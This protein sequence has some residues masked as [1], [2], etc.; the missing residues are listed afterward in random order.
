[1]EDG[2]DRQEQSGPEAGGDD[3]DAEPQGLVHGSVLSVCGG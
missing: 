3:R 2:G 1:V